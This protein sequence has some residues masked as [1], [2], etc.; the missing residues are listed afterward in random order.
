LNAGKTNKNAMKTLIAAEYSSVQVE[1]AKN[2]EA[3][4]LYKTPEFRQMNPIGKV[5]NSF[6]CSEEVDWISFMSF[7][8]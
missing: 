7:K 6:P 4:M 2:F 8:P 3:G 1:L 5:C